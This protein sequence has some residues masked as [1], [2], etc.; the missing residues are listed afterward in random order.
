MPPGRAVPKP[1]AA[2][3]TRLG[4]PAP[5]LRWTAPGVGLAVLLQDQCENDDGETLLL[6]SIR[7]GIALP[8][9]SHEGTELTCVLE[10]SFADESGRYGIGD[11]AEVE[12]GVSH[13]PVAD[14]PTD[15][16]C[17]IATRG[18]LRFAGLIGRLAGAFLKI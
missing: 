6:L 1:P 5:K 11:M 3:L 12:E 10:G 9:H 7:P 13:R 2:T 4:L 18:R 15:C 16:I 17:L 8:G 14:S